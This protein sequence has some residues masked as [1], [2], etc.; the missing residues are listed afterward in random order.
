M[1]PLPMKITAS[2]P[3]RLSILAPNLDSRE[4][5]ASTP[6]TELP[7]GEPTNDPFP[8][9]SLAEPLGDLPHAPRI[10]PVDTDDPSHAQHLPLEQDLHHHQGSQLLIKSDGMCL[11]VPTNLQSS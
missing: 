7:Q 11:N 10:P 2:P 8:P 1:M 5:K 6:P 9:Y 3:I 4:P